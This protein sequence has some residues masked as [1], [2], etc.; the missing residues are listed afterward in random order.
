MAS[1]IPYVD[2]CVAHCPAAEGR[3]DLNSSINCY[4]EEQCDQHFGVAR[5]VDGVDELRSRAEKEISGRTGDM[6]DGNQH[7]NDADKA[8]GPLGAPEGG[9][10]SD[11]DPAICYPLRWR[12]RL[13]YQN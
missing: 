12:L 13:R 1:L 11:I 4:I 3:G 5:K 6:Q 7:G 10:H 9:S 2:S 8:V